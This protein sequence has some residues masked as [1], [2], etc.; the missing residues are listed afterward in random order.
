MVTSNLNVY[1]ISVSQW[2]VA[3][4]HHALRK[5]AWIIPSAIFENFA[6]FLS[7]N[8]STKFYPIIIFISCL[9]VFY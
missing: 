5:K 9:K 2:L 8:S 4:I 3:I 6:S 1:K 7:P